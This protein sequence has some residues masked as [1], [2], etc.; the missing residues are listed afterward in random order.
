MALE[1]PLSRR[2]MAFR[3]TVDSL[4]ENNEKMYLWTFTWAE[5]HCSDYYMKCWEKLCKCFRKEWPLLK[6]LR[7]AEM[8]PGSFANFGESHG[9]HI[10]ALLN[11]RVSIHRLKQLSDR[12][13]FG[14][15]HVVRCDK[16]GAYYLSKYLTKKAE[17]P[18]PKG[19]RSYGTIGFSD[20]TDLLTR[21]RD[22]RIQTEF[23]DNVATWQQ[24]LRLKQMT[25]DLI[26]TIYMNTK[27]FGAI[28]NWP[29]K[30][31]FYHGKHA[32]QIFSDLM[33]PAKERPTMQMIA[34]RWKT[35]GIQIMKKRG[36]PQAKNFLAP[37]VS[38]NETVERLDIGASY[39]DKYPGKTDGTRIAYYRVCRNAKQ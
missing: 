6:G 34:L 20:N 25:P 21:I 39:W 18:L 26:H 11:E 38:K 29:I 31:M 10:H 33:L 37:Q 22:V 2:A 3:W 14:R 13:G 17:V 23:G 30:R 8:H 28:E 1:Y 4:F 35:R 7:V 15:I 16:N 36:A 9:L 27:L 24:R 19:M 5:P 32:K 12:C